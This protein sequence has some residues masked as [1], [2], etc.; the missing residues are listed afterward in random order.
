MAGT[1]SGLASHPDEEA[2]KIVEKQ[3][4]CLVATPHSSVIYSIAHALPGR[5]GFSIPK[6]SEDANYVKRLQ[7][8]LNSQS[9]V[10]SQYVNSL[11]GSIVITYKSGI[12]P[13][14]EMRSHLASLIQ[15][16]NNT[17]VPAIQ[18]P[19]NSFL[20]DADRKEDSETQRKEDTKSKQDL[21]KLKGI[22]PVSVS[23]PPCISASS[24]EPA[25]VAYSIA[26][27]IPGRV[28]FRVPRIAQDPKYVQRLE[29]LF[30]KD[31]AVTNERVNRAAASIVITYQPA[32]ISNSQKLCLNVVEQA[33]SYLSGLIQSAASDNCYGVKS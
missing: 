7:A 15:A 26:H 1:T 4:D 23:P 30:K 31:P 16:A 12:M 6:I 11:A 18:Q 24:Q 20:E 33:I 28:R 25:K 19:V 5:V 22:V 9:E 3:T 17:D 32:K 8:L 10:V 29:A 13:D 21:E 14:S 2:R 27:A